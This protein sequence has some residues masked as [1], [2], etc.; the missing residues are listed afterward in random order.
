M[1][2]QK[3]L[4]VIGDPIHDCYL[5]LDSSNQTSSYEVRDGGAYNVYRNASAALDSF[6]VEFYPNMNLSSQEVYK[7]LRINDMQDI[8]LCEEKNKS[9]YYS[10]S[11]VDFFVQDLDS[12]FS[13]D[14][15]IIFSDYNKGV[16]NSKLKLHKRAPLKYFKCSVSDTRYR[17]LNTQYLKLFKTNIWRCTGKE[18][19]PD[20]ARNFDY[21]IWTDAEK[22]VLIMGRSQEILDVV[23]FDPISPDLVLDTCGAGDTFTATFAS[24]LFTEPDIDLQT[25]TKA[26]KYS[27]DC[28]QYVI[29]RDK[30]SIISKKM[31]LFAKY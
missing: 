3:K 25:I 18:Y 16:L 27:L 14:S 19:N 24:F 7:I 26:C 15:L 22:P 1:I 20:Y 2:N 9:T 31:S 30:T 21:T 11:L 13:Q 4:I 6:V 10:S 12:L 8:S 28:C 17:T 5:T 29:Q 23:E